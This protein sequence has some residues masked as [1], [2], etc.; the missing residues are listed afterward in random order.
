MLTVGIAAG[1]RG[2]L[3]RSLNGTPADNMYEEEFGTWFYKDN[4]DRLGRVARG[5]D[6]TRGVPQFDGVDIR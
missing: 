5:V 6:Q 3:L 2:S 4:G 1:G